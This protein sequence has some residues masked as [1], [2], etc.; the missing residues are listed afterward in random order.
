MKKKGKP[1]GGKKG[2]AAQIKV[3]PVDSFF[4][5]FSSSAGDSDAGEDDDEAVREERQADLERM[6][7]L[8]DLCE[9]PL[10]WYTGQAL[11]DRDSDSGDDFS[12]EDEGDYSDEDED[13]SEDDDDSDDDDEGPRRQAGG[14]PATK[15][16]PKG[17]AR[18]AGKPGPAADAQGNPQD[19]KQQ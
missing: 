2:Q 19:C 6:R 11:K 18:G 16:G 1:G 9:H 12:D 8:I 17:G 7:E 5:F 14:K 4:N 10:D 15:G 13:D 3:V